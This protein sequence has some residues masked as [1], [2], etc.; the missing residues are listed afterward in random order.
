MKVYVWEHGVKKEDEPWNEFEAG[1][2]S[3]ICGEYPKE[4][5]RL[6]TEFYETAKDF[7]EMKG[8]L[9][10]DLCSD[11]PMEYIIN[12]IEGSEE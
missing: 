2:V 4:A 1:V 9:L 7:L 3:L 5:S 12:F 10:S 6:I 11:D 8:D